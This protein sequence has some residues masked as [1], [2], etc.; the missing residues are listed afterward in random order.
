MDHVRKVVLPPDRE[1]KYLGIFTKEKAFYRAF[2]P[3]LIIISLQH[4]AALMVNMVDN[5]MLGS[6]TEL[7][8]SGATL[9]N[10]IHFVM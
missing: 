9:V 5:L 1:P 6:Y 8:L 3:L 2:I 7:A 4:L 10:Q